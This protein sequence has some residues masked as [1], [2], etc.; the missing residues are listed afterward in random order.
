M[1]VKERTKPVMLQILESLNYRSILTFSEKKDYLN[2]LKGYEGEVQFDDCLEK[3]PCNWLILNDL[4]LK[5]NG[6]MVQL[7]ALI[8]TDD[9]IYLYE[10]KNYSGSY[11]YKEDALHA[12]SDFVIVNPLTQVHRSQPFLYNLIRKLGYK[13]EVVPQVVFIHPDFYLYHLPRDKPFLFLNQL[14][15][16]FEKLA[17]QHPSA[18]VTTKQLA[19]RLC[20]LHVSDYRPLDLPEYEYTSLKKGVLCPV[21]FSFEH[22]NMRETRI[23]KG[24]GHKESIAK[25][26][27]RSTEEFHLLFPDLKVTKNHI[28]DWCGKIYT[29]QRVQRALSG[30]FLSHSSR[31]FTYYAVDNPL[32][33][34]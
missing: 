16:H 4:R 27:I 26:I 6:T 25:A 14:S 19:K 17:E 22:D 24:C 31:R 10:I 28:H 33:V 18:T 9:T 30:H 8:L 34:K 20:E 23:C 11:E 15:R 5:E 29:E 1:I 12:R 21:C 32:L 7:D 13:L 3:S 2:Q